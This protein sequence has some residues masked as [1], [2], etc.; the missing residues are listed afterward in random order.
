MIEKLDKDYKSLVTK[1]VEA[2]KDIMPPVNITPFAKK[3]FAESIFKTLKDN[4]LNPSLSSIFFLLHEGKIPS[5][6]EY[7][8]VFDNKK[9]FK[10]L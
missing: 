6:E 1:L 4:D 8:R 7:L 2:N 3:Q 5:I 10:L 9:L